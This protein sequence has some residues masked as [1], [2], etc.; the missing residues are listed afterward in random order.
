MTRS[1]YNIVVVPIVIVM[2]SSVFFV[3]RTRGPPQRACASSFLTGLLLFF[4][5]TFQA[6]SVTCIHVAAVI[7]I[8][9]RF[10]SFNDTLGRLLHPRPI[11][12]SSS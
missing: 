8:A 3:F 10:L 5:S 7:P 9:T 4:S 2:V 1:S 11:S 12:K 6:A